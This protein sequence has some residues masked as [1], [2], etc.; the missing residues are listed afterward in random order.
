MMNFLAETSLTITLSR[1]ELA[2][3]VQQAGA[4]GI[5]GLGGT[6]QTILYPDGTN[7]VY[8]A[9]ERALLARGALAV[10]EDRHLEVEP[11]LLDLIRLCIK[12]AYAVTVVL[13]TPTPGQSSYRI[14]HVLPQIIVIHRQRLSGVH[15]I[16]GVTGKPFDLTETL[17]VLL[18][19]VAPPL[20]ISLQVASLL[21]TAPL[22]Q[23]YSIVGVDGQ[24]WW[25]EVS[26]EANG[27]TS[28][29]RSVTHSEL[30]AILNDIGEPIR[31]LS[32]L[33]IEP[34]P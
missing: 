10:T 25:D 24:Y 1:E 13:T 27:S 34:Q 19:P 26:L 20:H 5:L 14:F 30:I 15:E 29:A 21:E 33:Q 8:A 23:E 3:L 17:A 18:P 32:Q 12:P 28:A 4:A 9:T 31:V 11:S 2:Y 22:T 7:A 16:H 6:T